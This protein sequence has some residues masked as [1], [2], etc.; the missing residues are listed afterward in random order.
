MVAD[1]EEGAAVSGTAV[2]LLL[3][4]GKPD[5]WWLRADCG[6]G[7]RTGKGLG[8]SR[9][10]RTGERDGGWLRRFCGWRDR[11]WKKGGVAV[12]VAFVAVMVEEGGAV[13]GEWNGS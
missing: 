11:D 8:R 7:R 13:A 9:E 3:E 2:E 6:G 1:F 10:I 5:E 12:W 4:K